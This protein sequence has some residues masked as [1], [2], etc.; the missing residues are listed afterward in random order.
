MSIDVRRWATELTSR[1]ANAPTIAAESAMLAGTLGAK[2]QRRA[3]E[4]LLVFARDCLAK[5]RTMRARTGVLAALA[6]DADRL[7][8]VERSGLLVASNPLAVSRRKLL[9]ALANEDLSQ[10]RGL[11]ERLPTYL[12]LEQIAA[13]HRDDYRSYRTIL[14]HRPT[15]TLKAL[16]A[17]ADA[18]FLVGSS[19][20]ALAEEIGV[21]AFRY[22]ADRSPEHVATIAST[23]LDDAF[24]ETEFSEAEENSE[25]WQGLDDPSTLDAVFGVGAARACL[26]DWMKHVTLLGYRIEERR[27][28]SRTRSRVFVLLS[29]LQDFELTYAA[30][31]LQIKLRAG[32]ALSSLPTNGALVGMDQLARAIV[33]RS[34]LFEVLDRPW[35]RGR[36]KMPRPG[37]GFYDEVL[38]QPYLEDFLT[39]EETFGDALVP[40]GHLLRTELAEGLTVND[41]ILLSRSF[42][43]FCA[44]HTA[45]LHE[46]AR[47]GAR[48][49]WNSMVVVLSAADLADILT[50]SGV[51]AKALGSFIRV[52]SLDETAEFVDLQYTPFLRRDDSVTIL[53]RVFACSNLVRNT[54]ARQKVRVSNAG[55]LFNDAVADVIRTAFPQVVVNCDVRSSSEHGEIDVALLEEETLYLFECKHTLFGG[56]VHEHAELWNDIVEAVAQLQKCERILRDERA[57]KAFLENRFP[58]GSRS[59]SK[60]CLV[61]VTSVRLFSGLEIEGVQVREWFTFRN[62]LKKGIFE[63]GLSDG[64]TRMRT[65]WSAWSG[66]QCSQSDLDEYLSPDSKVT[67]L[68]RSWFDACTRIE[69]QTSVLTL[70]REG[71]SA[72]ESGLTVEHEN[73]RMEALGFRRLRDVESPAPRA[74]TAEDLVRGVDERSSGGTDGA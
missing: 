39:G 66:E 54:M 23:V 24:R 50:A 49:V 55:E 19:S 56:S 62:F 14:R 13:S 65:L 17:V 18:S 69:L 31:F 15:Q 35:P 33:L 40:P 22:L 51:D 30:G 59:F 36:M 72:N 28:T 73:R 47:R 68:R 41:F 32:G 29:P 16:L 46:V 58:K 10:F 70:A 25:I 44:F 74:A 42:R 38:A 64:T 52:L 1:N 48:V 63:V 12:A 45:M 11:A 4:E 21:G 61:V 60:V 27:T 7:G 43:F 67:R 71:V 53:P 5:D 2:A 3:A 37:S 57:R 6:L 8:R 26:H 34:E 20:E 9:D